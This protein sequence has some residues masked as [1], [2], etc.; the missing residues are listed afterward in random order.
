MTGVLDRIAETLARRGLTLTTSHPRG[1]GWLSLQIADV[2]GSPV[3][4]Q[5]FA[6]QERASVVAAQTE[7]RGSVPVPVLDEAV[8]VQRE[9]VDRRLPALHRL[10]ASPGATLVTHRAE[11]RGVVRGVERDGTATYTK[12][13]RPSRTAATLARARLAVDGVAVPPVT[14][15]DVRRGTVTCEQL[16]GVRLH[17]LLADPAVSSRRL[18]CVA[19][20]VGEALARLHRTLPPDDLGW[21]DASAEL[22]VT[23][24][25][26]DHA[27]TYGLLD[28]ALMGSE[29]TVPAHLERLRAFAAERGSS[30]TLIHRDLHDKQVLVGGGDAVG[31]L[32]F[33]LATTGEAALDLANLLVHLE[34]RALQGLCPAETSRTCAESLVDGYAPDP[35]VWRRVPGYALATQLRLAAV[36]SFRP[37]SAWLGPL[38]LARAPGPLRQQ[39]VFA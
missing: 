34:L 2:D 16:P 29:T 38:L 19:R 31:I 26:W 1:Q 30:P 25:W 24:G 13:L 32:D 12:V 6:D 36:Y 39:E 21:H 9:G 23:Q 33:D 35:S 8:L 14:A 15:S 7:A 3:A 37:G 20:A 28:A 5:W 10:V 4:G 17:A 18:G 27:A 11:R 22:E